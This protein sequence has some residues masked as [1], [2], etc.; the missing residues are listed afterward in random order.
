[1]PVMSK[2]PPLAG[3]GKASTQA[4]RTQVVGER[5][6]RPPRELQQAVVPVGE[7]LPEVGAVENVTLQ[8][9]AGLQRDPSQR[10]VAVETRALEQ[11]PVP[12]DQPLCVRVWIVRIVID[13]IVAMH[14]RG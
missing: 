3:D 13:D 5:D 10:G 12:K 14:R 8:D 1:M 6:V 7:P 4:E 2:A 11:E 9:F